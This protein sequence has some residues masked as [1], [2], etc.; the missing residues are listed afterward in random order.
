MKTLWIGNAALKIRLHAGMSE[1]DAARRLGI[2]HGR[3]CNIE[4]GRAQPWVALLGRYQELFGHDPYILA[5]S[6]AEARG[7]FRKVE[8]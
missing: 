3:L 5:H 6:L 2:T 7:E 8:R 1:R 4:R